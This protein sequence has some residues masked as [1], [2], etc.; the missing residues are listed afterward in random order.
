MWQES[1]STATVWWFSLKGLLYSPA[2]CL[3]MMRTALTWLW[4]QYGAVM[5]AK[6]KRC[7]EE[8]KRGLCYL[9]C[10]GFFWK[11]SVSGLKKRWDRGMLLWKCLR[12]LLSYFTLNSFVSSTP[13]NITCMQQYTVYL[14]R[15]RGLGKRSLEIHQWVILH[16]PQQPRRDY[17]GNLLIPPQPFFCL[18]PQQQSAGVL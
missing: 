16:H 5:L 7:R 6:I 13:L 10:T 8:E 4:V 9:K 2:F 18:W 1:P 17:H 12:G 3:L 15:W 11:A 14:F